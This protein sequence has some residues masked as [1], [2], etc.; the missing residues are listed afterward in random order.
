MTDVKPLARQVRRS[1]QATLVGLGLAYV[2]A[3]YLAPWRE[4]DVVNAPLLV[5]IGL[6]I[7]ALSLSLRAVRHLAEVVPPPRSW[8]KPF[9]AISSVLGIAIALL[10]ALYLFF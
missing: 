6:T 7:A 3:L 5:V 8:I 1:L 4:P 10:G 9:A 2:G